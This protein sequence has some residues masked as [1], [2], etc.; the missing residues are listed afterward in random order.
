MTGIDCR[1]MVPLY[2]DLEFK[3]TL[4]YVTN[5]RARGLAQPVLRACSRP[6]MM[7]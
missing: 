3:D 6:S 1:V 4:T 7:A 2:G 5:W